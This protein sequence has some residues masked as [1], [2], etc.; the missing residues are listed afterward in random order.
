MK[1]QGLE[2]STTMG[3]SG[4]TPMSDNSCGEMISDEVG[5]QHPG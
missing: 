4:V 3:V 2:W 1:K 5:R